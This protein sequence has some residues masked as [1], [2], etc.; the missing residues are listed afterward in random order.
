MEGNGGEGG[1]DDRKV[2]E[3]EC[4]LTALLVPMQPFSCQTICYVFHLLP[5]FTF[6]PLS[7]PTIT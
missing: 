3:N 7:F 1:I 4:P 2:R 5:Y 6:A